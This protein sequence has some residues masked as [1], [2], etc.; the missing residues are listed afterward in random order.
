VWAA[1]NACVVAT[2]AGMDLDM[3]AS[4]A[5]AREG[6]AAG[7][8]LVELLAAVRAGLAAGAAKRRAAVAG[9]ASEG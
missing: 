1:A 7:W 3:A 4:R 2:T 8:S 6:G 9:D 5:L